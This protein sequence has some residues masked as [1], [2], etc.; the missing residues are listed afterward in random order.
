LGGIQPWS[1]TPEYI[2]GYAQGPRLWAGDNNC[3]GHTVT[4]QAEDTAWLNQSI[5]APTPGNTVNNLGNTDITAWIC[6]SVYNNGAM[7]NSS[8]QGQL[9]HLHWP[10]EQRPA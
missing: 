8:S 9:L 4:T 1:E 10:G 3:A 2:D 7:N 6:A 5:D